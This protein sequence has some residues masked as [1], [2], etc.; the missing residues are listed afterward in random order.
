MTDTAGSGG[1]RRRRMIAGL[2]AAV[3]STA[4]PLSA[5]PA[6]LPRGEIRSWDITADVLVAGSGAAGVSAA[7][8]ARAS[9]AE[10]LLIESLPRLGGASAMSGGVVYAGGGTALQ[11]ALNIEDSAEAMYD[12]IVACGARH[13]QLDKIQLYCEQSPAHFDWLVEQGVPYQSKYTPAK[14]LPFGD[15]SL[16]YS[17]NE[18]AWPAVELAP[19]APRGH[20][21]GV[22][23]MNGGRTL[24]EALLA[25]LRRSG[26][27]IRAGLAGQRLVIERDGRAAGMTVQSADGPLHIRARR[28]VVLACGGFIHNRDMLRRYAPELYDCSVPWGNAGDL[29]AGINMGIAAG[30]AALRMHQG[31]AIAPIYPPEHVLSGIVVNAAGQ[32]F[33]SEESYH[34]VLGDAIAFHQQGRAWLITD[35]ES[36][37]RDR[38]DN[39]P[40]VA[41]GNTLGDLA[42]RVGFPQGALQHTV[43]YYNRFA[44][45]GRDPLFHKGH[46]YLRPLQGPPYRA[47]NLSVDRAFFPAHTFGGLHTDV[48]GRVID[49]FG[50]AIPGLYAAGRTVAGLPTA[51]YIASGLSLGDCTFFGRRAGVAAAAGERGA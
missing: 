43:A 35:S 4:L 46:G 7:L 9:G 6:V 20:V 23:G 15:E 48:D 32:R 31:F 21:P 38:Q 17:G 2:G 24:M 19:P 40:L 12:F 16:Y 3:G 27:R 33:I 47:W 39:F 45:A 8:E 29:G 50:D 41:E 30:G 26:A 10:V 49:G 25:R 37:Y 44:S 22:A 1:I 51:P 13:P 36:S 18:L 34:G 42:A 14:G 28:G 5:G 11:R